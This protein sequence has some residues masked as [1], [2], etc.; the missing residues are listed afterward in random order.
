[1]KDDELE[2][3]ISALLEELGTSFRLDQSIGSRSLGDHLEEVI[4]KAATTEL[5]EFGVPGDAT[6]LRRSAEGIMNFFYRPHLFP[7]MEPTLLLGHLVQYDLLPRELPADSPVEAV[8][9]LESYCHL[10]GDLFGWVATGDYEITMWVLDVS[11]HG[12]RA[13][14]AAVAI[15]IILADTDPGIP[16]TSL[17]KEVESRFLEMRNP[18]DP[19]CIYATGVFLRITREGTVEYFSAGHPPILVKRHRGPVELFESTAIPLGLFPEMEKASCSFELGRE[20]A[21]VICTDGLLELR[22]DDGEFFGIDH[23]V[24]SLIASDGSPCGVY[25]SLTRAIGDFHE[26]ERLEDDLSFVA[27]RL[28]PTERL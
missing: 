2:S 16:L 6:E 10:S 5:V 8:A 15:K 28:R 22:N 1:M 11:G 18:D 13:G 25:S 27:L 9:M 21:L 12:V 3:T 7:G 23:T 20:D 19:G 14:F 4:R 17:A 24:E 26:L